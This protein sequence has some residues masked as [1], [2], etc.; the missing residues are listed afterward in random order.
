MTNGSFPKAVLFDLDDTILWTSKDMEKDWLVVCEH[1]QDKFQG[2]PVETVQT[3]IKDYREW[4]WTDDHRHLNGRLNPMKTLVDNIHQALKTLGIDGSNFS[5][6]MAV[7]WRER[8]EQHIEPFPGALDTLVHLCEEGVRLAMITN[9]AS[10][11]QRSKINKFELEQYFDH[12]QVEGEF[13]KGKPEPQ[14]YENALNKLGV[15]ASNAWMAGD[16]IELDVG[17]PQKLG[18]HGIWVDHR[19]NGLPEG[20]V[21]QPN[22]IVQRIFELVAG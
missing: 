8:R 3:A 4:F 11:M 9:G 18:V 15:K 12:V 6:E 21:V 1:F 7:L 19:L 20:S 22:R 2:K 5:E 17:A 10:E 16:N 14:V 13:G